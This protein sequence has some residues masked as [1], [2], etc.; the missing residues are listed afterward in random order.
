[1]ASA[2]ELFQRALR[3]SALDVEQVARLAQGKAAGEPA[4]RFDCLLHVQAEV[5][6]GDVGL[7]LD[8]RLA[9][10]AHAAEYLPQLVAAKGK[11]C[12]EGMQRALAGLEFVGMLGVERKVG[13]AVLQHDA[14][15]RR[16]YARTEHAVEAVDQ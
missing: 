16:D 13:A 8:L 15:L 9:V 6:H 3:V 11:R 7:K 12:D 14:A 4:R 5:D 2:L 10:G 1:M